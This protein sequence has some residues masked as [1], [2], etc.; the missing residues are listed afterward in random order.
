MESLT[1]YF[2][3]FLEIAQFLIDDK[4]HVNFSSFLYQECC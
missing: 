4:F 1:I 2:T 3:L